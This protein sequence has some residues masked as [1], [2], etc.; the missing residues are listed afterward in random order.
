MLASFRRSAK[1]WAA[2]A[3]L[4]IALIA[5]VVTGFGTG[6]MGGLGG[7]GGGGANAGETLA[8]VGD[9]KLTEE[10]ITDIVNRQYA[11]ARQQQPDLELTAFLTSSFQP[12]VDQMVTALAIQA[13]GTAQGLT[14]SQRMIDREIVNIPAFRNF[15]GQF[16]EQTFRNALA[17]QN[18]T[19]A[20][21]RQ[22]IARSLM[23]RQ[24]LGPVARGAAVPEALARE[25]AN[26][27]L[28]RRRGSIGVV[29]SELLRQGIEPTEPQIAQ[30]YNANRARFTI[31]ERRVIKYAMLGPEQVAQA[32][33]ATDQE[34]AAFYR[35]NAAAYGGQERRTVQHLVLQDQRAAQQA[36]Q[37]LRSGRSFADVASGLGFAAADLTYA[38]QAQAEFA[39]QA[40][41]QV[42]QAAFAAPQGGVVGPFEAEGVFHIVRVEAVN[43]TAARPLDAVRGEIAQRIQQGKLADALNALVGRVEDRLGEGASI[44]EVARA[45][46]LNLVTT[47]PLTESGQAPGQQ[48]AI[49]PEMQPM[50]RGAFEI[51]AEDPEPVV[52]EVVPNQRFAL[53]SLERVIPAAPPPLAQ[54][55]AQVREALIQQRGQERARAL[56]IQIRDRI[57]GGLAPAQAFAQAQPRLPAPQAVDLQRLEISRSGGQAP[58]PLVALFSLPQGRAHVMEAPN[59]A[60]WFVIH[61]AQRTAGNASGQQ[62]L[63]NTTR[64]EFATSAAE[65]IAQQF[66]RAVEIASDVERNAEA[67]RAVRRRMLTNAGQ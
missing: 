3:I 53:V 49:A 67:I 54:I 48:F 24:L 29:P 52:E 2:G 56:A 40:N 65:E 27:L 39:R 51:D 16:D 23:Q 8:R 50:L 15:T 44:E 26:L 20:Q 14:V 35:R 47:P 11:M 4:F 6:G 36:V 21:L 37:Q 1:S 57:N 63:I 58:P 10:E 17:G 60:G 31:P 42:A 66:A 62:Q 33:Q 55:R 7:L 41:P 32:A 12:I 45:E 25:Y 34:I 64:A 5:I 19:E 22:D 43:R 59:G 61:H 30:Y 13:F 46:R 28:E 18:I 9:E 38:N